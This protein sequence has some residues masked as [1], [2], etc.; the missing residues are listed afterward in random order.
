VHPVIV[1]DIVRHHI[2]DLQREARERRL[3]RGSRRAPR[4]SLRHLGT[5]ALHALLRVGG[6]R[7]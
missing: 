4:G 2:A 6:G 3:Q 5:H 7:V 1:E